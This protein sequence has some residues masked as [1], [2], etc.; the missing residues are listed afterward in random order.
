MRKFFIPLFTAMIFFSC[1]NHKNIPDV[2]SIKI[3]LETKRF[4]QDFFAMDT[5]KVAQSMKSIF[6]KY[7]DFL[8]AFTANMLGLDLDSLLIP[9]NPETKAV[10]MFIR[11]YMPIKDSADLLYKNFNKETEA[12]K[13]GLQFVKYY[14]PQYKV[15]ESIITF[16][17]PINANFETSFGV[18]GDVLTINSFGIGLQLHLG[19]NFSF[20]KSREGLEQYPEYISKNFDKQHIPVNCMRNI[21][22]D[23]FPDKSNGK[24]LV[25]QI[26]DKGKR[27]FLLTKFLPETPEFELIGYTKQQL[28]DSYKNEAVIWDF[29]LNNDLLNKTDQNIVQNYIGE[30]P[31][32]P[33]LGEDAPGNIGTFSGL[34]IIKKFMEKFPET[35]LSQ[36]MKMD[37]RDIYNKSKYKP[38]R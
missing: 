21:V 13:K 33:E 25:E 28:K 27:M 34:Q 15:P 37:A 32:T 14:F 38:R 24:A 11:D 9:N 19:K 36:L 6:K 29:F 4:E 20:Y 17:G 8:P 18:Q 2:S 5:T 12:I 35:S 1:R 22:D 31:K 30:S 3:N 23:L 10:R 16:I 7:P 26:I